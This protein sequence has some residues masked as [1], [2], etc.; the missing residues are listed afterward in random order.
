MSSFRNEG[1]FVEEYV[2]DVT[3]GD[4]G[5]TGEVTLY[6]KANHRV[7]PLGSIV[8]DFVMHVETAFVGATATMDIGDGDDPNG[9]AEA[10]A[11]AALTADS[12]HRAGSVAGALIW[13]DTNDHLI[14]KYVTA[15]ADGQISVTVNTAAFTAGKAHIYFMCLRGVNS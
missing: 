9:Y 2:Y 11:V 1:M 13:D 6:D 4:S 3:G 10:I 8:L 14:G 12:L 15:A 7:L 5:G